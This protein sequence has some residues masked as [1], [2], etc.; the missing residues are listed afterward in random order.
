MPT[1]RL[2]LAAGLA[3]PA[4]ALP[5]RARAQAAPLRI[6]VPAPPGGSTDILARALGERAGAALGQPVLVDN[7]AGAGG[8]TGAEAAARAAPDGNTLV[9][10]HN[11]T[12]ASNQAM[13]P[14][15]PYR[16]IEDFTPVARL[17][18]VPHVLVVAQ[19]APDATL[20]AL[21]ARGRGGATLTYASSQAGSASHILGETLVRRAGLKAQHAP[22]RG[23]GAAAED[24]AA[25]YVDFYVATF[26]SVA[27]A[28]REGRLRALA[29]GAEAR[30]AAAP[31]V[32]TAA[33][34]G[35][36]YLAVEAWFGLFGPAGTAAGRVERIAQAVLAALAEPATQSRLQAAGFTPAPLP[37]AAFAAF[38]RSEVERWSEL[39]RLTGVRLDG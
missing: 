30:L 39:V 34:A 11:Q 10:G 38:Q 17:A 35:A 22:Y 18:T 15:L 7:R 14:G 31:E 19:E 3:L 36:P 13:M 4:L 9:L 32:P 12:H 23:A 6:I 37:P 21:I 24:T 8:V 1:R 26:P 27:A 25:G 29:L 20:A 28:L 33:E 16:V 5:A 2:A